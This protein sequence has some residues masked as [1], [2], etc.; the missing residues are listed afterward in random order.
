VELGLQG[1]TALVT[2]GDAMMRK[3]ADGNGTSFD[4]AIASFLTEERPH[5]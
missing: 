5:I 4:E 1:R 2:G 3:R